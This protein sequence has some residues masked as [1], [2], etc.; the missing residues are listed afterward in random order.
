[1]SGKLVGMVFEHYPSGGGELLLAVKLA[2]NAHDTGQHIFPSVATLATQTRQS[3]R[4]V[5]YQLKRMVE[6]GWLVLVKEAMGGGRGGGSGRPREYKIHPDWI[7]AHDVRVPESERPQWTFNEPASKL[8]TPKK[9]G[10]NFAPSK[11]GKWV[12]PGAEMGATAVAEMGATAVAPEPSLTVKEQIPPNPPPGGADGFDE[13]LDIWPACRRQRVAEARERY[14]RLLAKGDVTG[15]LL[16]Q[17]A[18][19]LAVSQQW[20]RDGGR[21]APLPSNWLRREGWKDATAVVSAGDW[22]DSQEGVLA[23]AQSLGMP[24]WDRRAFDEGRGPHWLAYRA[25]VIQAVQQRAS[26]PPKLRRVA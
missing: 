3:E 11:S 24:P 10:A 9:M 23:K 8:S 16:V 13:L 19:L 18:T 17:A 22:T 7:R 12:Q 20:G 26:Q 5:Q 21:F 14:C 15:R 2:D 6:S 1:M 4:T 25:T